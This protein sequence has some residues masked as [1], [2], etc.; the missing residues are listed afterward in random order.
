MA[1]SP[2]EL[3]PN[4]LQ[5]GYWPEPEFPDFEPTYEDK[6][7]RLEGWEGDSDRPKT[8]ESADFDI[9]DSDDEHPVIRRATDIREDQAQ[10]WL[11][12]KKWGLVIYRCT[13]N[14]DVKWAQFM[15]VFEAM[16]RCHTIEDSKLDA[17]LAFDVRE[18]EPLFQSD[19]LANVREHFQT[20]IHSDEIKSELQ[21]SVHQEYNGDADLLHRIHSVQVNKSTPAH[22]TSPRYSYFIYVDEPAMESVLAHKGN[23]NGWRGNYCGWVNIVDIDL[24]KGPV[25]V[26]AVAP[27][28]LY[29][30]Y[31]KDLATGAC[32]DCWEYRP[33]APLVDTGDPWDH[34][35]GHGSARGFEG[36]EGLTAIQQRLDEIMYPESYAE[37][38]ENLQLN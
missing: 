14:D 19:D 34:W 16:G 23:S 18:D 26:R 2:A 13:Y 35:A 22:L 3:D 17:T 33:R 29:P 12:Q 4:A 6:Y 9:S 15:E 30:Q 10:R 28:T 38:E 5:R 20:W 25:S 32:G 8:P 31:Y 1:Y 7:E 36:S 37:D 27:S 24:P 11:S 21:E